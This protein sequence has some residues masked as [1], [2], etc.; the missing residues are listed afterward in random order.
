[1]GLYLAPGNEN[2]KSILSGIYVDKTGLINVINST[3]NTPDKLTCISRP[4]KYDP[5]W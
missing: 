1:M 5:W 4:R 2:F 3:I